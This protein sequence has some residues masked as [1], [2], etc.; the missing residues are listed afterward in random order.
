[1]RSEP[2]LHELRA[3][4]R[5]AGLRCTGSRVAVLRHFYK[6]GHTSSHAELFDA[7]RDAGVDRVTI[8]RV[9]MDFVT[10]GILSRTDLG[11]H[12]WRFELIAANNHRD[13]H[14]H[15]TCIDCG[16]VLC[17]PGVSLR[18]DARAR[19]PRAVANKEI[20]VQLKGRCD[21]CA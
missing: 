7:L 6:H 20:H 18:L 13:D 16:K 14:A 11:D 8:Y 2:E 5:A 15:F 10:A 12:V 3:R 21:K 9:L 1:M 19:A 17:L 4:I